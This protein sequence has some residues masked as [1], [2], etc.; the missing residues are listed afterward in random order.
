MSL[1]I[2]VPLLLLVAIV[3]VTWL[4]LIPIFGLKPDLALIVVTTWGLLAPIGEAAQWGFVLGILLDLNSGLPFGVHT[5]TLTIVGLLVGLGQR[6]FFRGNLIAPP[7]TV[8]LATLFDHTVILGI[9]ASLNESI[10]WSDYLIHITLPTSILNTLLAGLVFFP[11]QGLYRRLHPQIE[12][13]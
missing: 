2:L 9:L 5:L 4:P 11:L 6:A 8:I 3:Q 1:W 12:V 13:E 10:S 7:V